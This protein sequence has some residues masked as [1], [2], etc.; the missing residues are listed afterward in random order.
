MAVLFMKRFVY[1]ILVIYLVVTVTFFMMHAVPGGPFSGAKKVSP[2]VAGK[3]AEKYGLNEPLGLQYLNYLNRVAHLDLGLSLKYPG[4][5]V[6]ELIKE[7][8]PVSAL[9][10]LLA[11]AVSMATGLAM[12]ALA[13]LKRHRWPD[14]AILVTVTL[15]L[16][17]PNF[18]LASL[19]I[20]VFSLKLKWLPAAMWGSP[21]QT[22]LPVLALSALPAAFIA[23]LFRAEMIDTLEKDFVRMARAK[24]LS[25][26]RLVTCHVLKIAV[27]PVLSYLGPLAVELLTGMFIVEKI[28]AIPGLSQYFLNSIINRDYSVTLGITIFYIALLVAFNLLVDLAYLFLNP[29]AGLEWGVSHERA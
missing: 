7:S 3:I 8:F 17:V 9:L 14:L 13:A 21:L 25:D 23:R 12:G 18:A 15:G 19:L 10:G 28:F 22:I 5:A 20:Y 1:G 16:C 26:M 27:I 29:R 6:N 2:V 4:R 24:G 11:L